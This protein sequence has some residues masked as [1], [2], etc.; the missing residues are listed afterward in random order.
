ME[1]SLA[2]GKQLCS[3]GVVIYRITFTSETAALPSYASHVS[4]SHLCSPWRF[5][6]KGID[7][8]VPDSFEHKEVE[9]IL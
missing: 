2:L 3:S 5:Y 1:G 4:K 8:Q 6:M 9:S 7:A